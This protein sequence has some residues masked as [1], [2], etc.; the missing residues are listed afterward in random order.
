MHRKVLDFNLKFHEFSEVD[1]I[2]PH[3]G[4]GPEPHPNPQ[5]EAHSFACMT[6]PVAVV[7]RGNRVLV[8]T[9]VVL[10]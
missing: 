4:E 10:K 9:F 6:A 2:K 5:C 3:T 7:L 8:P 1:S